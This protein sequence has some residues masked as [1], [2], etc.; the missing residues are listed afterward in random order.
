M[1]LLLFGLLLAAPTETG[2][3]RSPRV[4]EEGQRQ[5]GPKGPQLRFH[6]V[7]LEVAAEVGEV[8]KR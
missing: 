1:S 7:R 6:D 3:K 2:G 5:Q 8:R 4:V